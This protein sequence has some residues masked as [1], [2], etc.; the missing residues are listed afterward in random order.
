MPQIPTHQPPTMMPTPSTATCHSARLADDYATIGTEAAGSL[1]YGYEVTWPTDPDEWAAQVVRPDGTRV[2]VRA[3][4]MQS[5]Q[6][7]DP[8]DVAE[9][10]LN[11]VGWMLANGALVIDAD[12]LA[13][14]VRRSAEA[15]S[16]A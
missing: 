5:R 4:W 13:H 9:Q 6:G 2:F 1:Y 3:A 14:A 16:R 15:H 8:L 10:M 7:R 11:L 12:A